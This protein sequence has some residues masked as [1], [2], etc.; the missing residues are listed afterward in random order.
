MKKYI[1]INNGNVIFKEALN[2]DDAKNKA[3]TV[4][5]C[6]HEILIREYKEICNNPLN[7]HYVNLLNELVKKY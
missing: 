2:M 6:S 1:I 4:V 5:D 3:L 7:D